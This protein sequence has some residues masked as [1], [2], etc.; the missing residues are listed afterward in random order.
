MDK[1]RIKS[2]V[3]QRRSI[4]AHQQ[5]TFFMIGDVF[6]DVF[7]DVF[8]DDFGYDFGYDFGDVCALSHDIKALSVDEGCKM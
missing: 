4:N 1:N 2:S 8:G 6:N 3:S 7:G 5:Q